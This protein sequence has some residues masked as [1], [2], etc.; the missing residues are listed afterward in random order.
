MI[1]INPG[2][3]ALVLAIILASFAVI[4]VGAFLTVGVDEAARH[5]SFEQ[6]DLRQEANIATYFE[7]AAL[8]MAA[9]ICW[10]SGSVNGGQTFPKWDR[11]LP[12]WR[13][14][15]GVFLFLSIDELAQIH[16]QFNRVKPGFTG[17]LS[18]VD[19]YSWVVVYLPGVVC[20]GIAFL[21]FLWRLPRKTAA[22]IVLS[23]VLYVLG[24]AG[25]E[26]VGAWQQVVDGIARDDA[27]NALR[28]IAEE[29]METGA[30]I[31]FI[32]VALTALAER[33][34]DI[35]LRITQ[36]RPLAAAAPGLA[37]PIPTEPMPAE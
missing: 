5:E 28:S 4:D 22:L 15:A 16:E 34:A 27:R 10:I 25:L 26:L 3:M 14:L 9:I 7:S 8:A 33:Q 19:H 18:F 23:G 1:Q 35:I 29:T 24:A 2:R 31:L 11:Y 36:R 6:F 32:W 37:T 17:Q 20:I 12:G 13:T 30:I 21:P